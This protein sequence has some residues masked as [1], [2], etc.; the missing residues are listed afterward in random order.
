MRVPDDLTATVRSW[1]GAAGEEWL[2]AL[3]R[4]VAELAVEWGLTVGAPYQPSGYCS[5]ALRVER[6]GE[7]CVLKVG[8]PDE[9]SAHEGTALRLYGG[10][11]AVALLAEDVPRRALLLER[12]EPG[13]PLRGEPDGVATEVVAGLARE[14]WVPPP[15]GHPFTTLADAAGHW[16]AT[17]ATGRHVEPR[18]RDEATALLGELVASAPP[19]VLLHC[20]LHPANVL[21]AARRPW[22]AIDPKPLAGDP[23]LDLAPVVRDRAAPGLVERRHAIVCD[24]TGAD[25]ARVRGWT[26]VQ[27]VEGAEWS[28]AV[29]DRR[30][31]D[32]F[33]AAAALVAALPG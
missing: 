31:G 11:A 1:G 3:P 26:L 20:D 25:P 5:L 30:S 12:C 21:R 4:L 22:L 10:R 17:L 24:V 14:L 6:G 27:C 32:E 7:P 15:A 16:A 33:A 28:Y 23:A 9:W 8:Y 29:G 13:T 18:L 2:G 19:P